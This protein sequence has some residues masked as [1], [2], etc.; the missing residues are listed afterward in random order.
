MQEII[1]MLPILFIVHDM[2]EIIGLGSWLKKNKELL[3]KK[4]PKISSTY[5]KYTT[6]G[7]AAAVTEELIICLLICIITRITGFYGLWLG[8]FVAYAI[9]LVIHVLESLILKK[10][11]PAVITSIICIP[12]SVLIIIFSI[13]NLSYSAI[14]VIIYSLTGIV[15][16]AINLKLSH[17]IMNA[18][19]KIEE[20]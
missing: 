9:H 17:L 4:Y 6:E 2:E 13:K 19:K 11:I 3:D 16:V 15:F 18:F 20:K 7:M 8:I 5:N 10:Y 14:Y 12:L 1:W